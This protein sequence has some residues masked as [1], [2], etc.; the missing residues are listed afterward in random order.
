MSIMRD[1]T[2]VP[3]PQAKPGREKRA[4]NAVCFLP[5]GDLKNLERSP[6]IEYKSFP[7]GTPN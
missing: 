7:D 6:K 1:A 4:K 3:T 2:E 5:W